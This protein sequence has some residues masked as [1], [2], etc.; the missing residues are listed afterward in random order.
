MPTSVASSDSTTA[1]CFG[2]SSDTLAETKRQSTISRRT[3]NLN[4]YV[5]AGIYCITT[6][7]LFNGL[8]SQQQQ[9]QP[10]SKESLLR[11]RHSRS[12]E[13]PYS[14]PPLLPPALRPRRLTLTVVACSVQVLFCS[15]SCSAFIV[16]DM[17]SYNITSSPPRSTQHS[18]QTINP[19]RVITKSD[20]HGG[21][22]LS[23]RVFYAVS[24]ICQFETTNWFAILFVSISCFNLELGNIAFFAFL[25][26]LCKQYTPLRYPLLS[27]CICATLW[28]IGLLLL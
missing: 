13:L 9:Q 20:S 4:P 3:Y 12:T 25:D 7:L 17:Y 8:D 10:S 18:S 27:S 1:L 5:Y 15:T 28:C 19:S 21:T 24:K 2:L 23:C 14:P 26:A 16:F 6:F 11:L 22:T